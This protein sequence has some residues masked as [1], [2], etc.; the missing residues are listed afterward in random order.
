MA[1]WENFFFAQVGAAAALAGLVFVGISIN[2]SKIMAYPSL[3]GRALE[4]LVLLLGLL[5]IASLMLVP[6]QSIQAVGIET[7]GVGMV[8]WLAVSAVLVNQWRTLDSQYKPAFLV[9]IVLAQAATIPFVTAGIVIFSGNIDGLYW[10]V[11][12][13][14]FSFL[15]VFINAWVLL[16]EINR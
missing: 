9:H 8:F 13:V 1:G 16:I 6:R 5:I 3:V 2:L 11:P 12:G 4:P 10:I 7:T 15:V 14:V